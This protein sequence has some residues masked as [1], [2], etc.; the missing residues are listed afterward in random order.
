MSTLRPDRYRGRSLGVTHPGSG[1]PIYATRCDAGMNGRHIAAETGATHGGSGLPIYGVDPCEPFPLGRHL[2][3]PLGT[4]PGSGL[5]L[6]AAACVPCFVPTCCLGI[7]PPGAIR[8]VFVNRSGCACIDGYSFDLPRTGPLTYE[9]SSETLPRSSCGPAPVHTSARL[10]CEPTF[11]PPWIFGWGQYYPG[12]GGG[13]YPRGLGVSFRFPNQFPL[14]P[15]FS[16][17]LFPP[18]NPP[19]LDSAGTCGPPFS[20]R[21]NGVRVCDPGEPGN[22]CLCPGGCASL[23]DILFMGL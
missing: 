23:I 11:S 5:P 18:S 20:A 1:L 21:I 14:G 2:A 6:A 8:V 17:C 15:G 3:G 22:P 19:L 7:P 9:F 13:L 16:T 4:H 10:R 12:G